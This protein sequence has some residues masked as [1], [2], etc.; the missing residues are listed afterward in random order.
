VTELEKREMVLEMRMKE[1]EM[2]VMKLERE[3]WNGI[4]SGILQTIRRT[5]TQCSR[6]FNG[7]RIREVSDG[8]GTKRKVS[9]GVGKEGFK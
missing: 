5:I 8:I 1:L 3:R 7:N 9:N 4:G 6:S 2:E